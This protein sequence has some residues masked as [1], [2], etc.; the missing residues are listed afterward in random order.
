MNLGDL[1]PAIIA[2]L[3]GND[4]EIALFLSR[5]TGFDPGQLA[6]VIIATP[7]DEKGTRVF[8][9][10]GDTKQIIALMH[11][12]QFMLTAAWIGG[13]EPVMNFEEEK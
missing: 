6:Y 8:A 4:P 2:D 9:N 12:T 3:G 7:F 5:L 11:M 13:P 1:P 10:T